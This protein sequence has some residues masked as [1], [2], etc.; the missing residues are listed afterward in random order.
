MKKKLYIAVMWGLAGVMAG[1]VGAAVD[2]FNSPVGVIGEK[3]NRI[4]L[5]VRSE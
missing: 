3:N 2:L 5:M 4:Y 1:E